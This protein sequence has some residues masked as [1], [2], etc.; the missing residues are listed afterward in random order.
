MNSD[1]SADAF[2]QPWPGHGWTSP[3]VRAAA[4]CSGPVLAYCLRAFGDRRGRPHRARHGRRQRRLANPGYD[5]PDVATL[6]SRRAAG[7]CCA[8][9]GGGGRA[10]LSSDWCTLVR[11]PGWHVPSTGAARAHCDRAARAKA[12]TQARA[13]ELPC[14]MLWALATTGC[15]YRPL[16]TN[17]RPCSAKYC[18]WWSVCRAFW[19]CHSRSARRKTTGLSLKTFPAPAVGSD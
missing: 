19:H 8:E 13:A 18:N 2:R 1:Q 15:Y 16:N 12:D 9:R 11:G 3:I 6:E 7:P 5:R 4:G 14:Q 17:G 10:A